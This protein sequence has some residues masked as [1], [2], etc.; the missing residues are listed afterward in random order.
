MTVSIE[1]LRNTLSEVQLAER[2]VEQKARDAE[3]S[4]RFWLSRSFLPGHPLLQDNLNNV[5]LSQSEVAREFARIGSIHASRE[6][7]LRFFVASGVYAA[8]RLHPCFQCIRTGKLKLKSFEDD[9]DGRLCESC[10]AMYRP[11]EWDARRALRAAYFTKNPR[12]I[13]II[14]RTIV[15][16]EQY[17]TLNRME[18][19][20]AAPR[21]SPSSR[22]AEPWRLVDA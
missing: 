7:L 1:T 18:R 13:E 12:G 5:S 16:S 4:E 15:L 21:K 14:E 20:A 2:Y 19:L 8:G 11:S 6:R 10:D 3:E 22:P 9:E 17:R